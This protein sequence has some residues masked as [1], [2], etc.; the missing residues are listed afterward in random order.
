M[1]LFLVR[2]GQTFSNRDGILQ[3]QLDTELSE[4]GIKQAEK[5]A[6]RLKDY[7]FDK[8]FSSDLQ[9]ASNT[10]KA[11]TKFHNIEIVYDKR[12]RERH[13]GDFGG[14]KRSNLDWDSLDGERW[15]KCPPNGESINDQIKRVKDFVDTL[16]SEGNVLIVSHGGTIKA[17]VHILL[18]KDL[19]EITLNESPKNTGVYIIEKKDDSYISIIENCDVHLN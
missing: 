16:H 4:L 5:V 10:A 8:V 13:F 9:R 14:K 17:L 19:E 3:G 15:E 2:H 1:K 6:K 7:T 12:L 11:I 18:G